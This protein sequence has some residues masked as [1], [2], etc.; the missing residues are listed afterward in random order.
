MRIN[1]GNRDGNP[2]YRVAQIVGVKGGFRR[3]MLGAK[4]TD[5]RVELQASR[6]P[7]PRAARLPTSRPHATH[8]LE[9]ALHT[10]GAAPLHSCHIHPPGTAHSP[11]A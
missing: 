7:C 11:A 2:V 3:Y 1:I 4:E 5:V 8:T 10:H 9:A 6:P